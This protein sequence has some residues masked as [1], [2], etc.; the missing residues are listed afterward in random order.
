MK[1]RNPFLPHAKCD[2]V[3]VDGRASEEIECNLRNLG[4]HVIR[5][6]KCSS[7][8]DAVSYHPD[9]VMHPINSRDIVIAPGVYDYYREELEFYGLNA[10]KGESEVG[11]AYPDNIGYNVGRVGKL[12]VHN[13]KYTDR[14]VRHHLDKEN[15]EWVY[16]KQGYSKCSILTVG[17]N[18][19]IT[20][21]RGIG[22]ALEEKPG[23]RVCLIEPG[24][25]ELKN[26]EYGFIGG[27]G[28]M[29]SRKELVLSGQ[30]SLHK[31]RDDIDCFLKQGN[32]IVQTVS[33][34]GIE[35]LGSM[36]FLKSRK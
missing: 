14:V 21:D 17:D 9:I 19:I 1:S 27:T 25:V 35:D 15:V 20:S 13:L 26:M 8:Y 18:R 4:I 22:N 16:V 34:K 33:N 10:I 29:M 6:V 32:I 36:L 5:T 3:I 24:C 12:A 28:G 11:M 2:L 31:S 30:Y 23:I 7:T